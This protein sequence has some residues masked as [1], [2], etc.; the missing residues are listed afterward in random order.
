MTGREQLDLQIV[1]T[2]VLADLGN[3]AGASIESAHKEFVM[4]DRGFHIDYWRLVVVV[5]ACP[6]MYVQHPAEDIPCEACGTLYPATMLHYG[7]CVTCWSA[8]PY[9]TPLQA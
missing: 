6:V 3:P 8:M 2:K 7:A 5:P 9:A 4:T 1:C